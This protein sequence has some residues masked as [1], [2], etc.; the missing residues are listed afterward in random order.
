MTYLTDGVHLYEVEGT[1]TNYGLIGGVFAIVRD[2]MTG[3]IRDMGELERAICE[4]V[5]DE[6]PT[7]DPPPAHFAT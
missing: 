7:E 4:L 2:C 6:R 1:V 5:K 3:A